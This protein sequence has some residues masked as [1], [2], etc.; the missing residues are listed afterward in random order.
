MAA[1]GA[2]LAGGDATESTST[3]G[4]MVE[5]MIGSATIGTTADPFQG[6]VTIQASNASYQNAAA[7][8]VAIGGILAIGL[9]M[10]NSSSGVT[11]LAQL[12]TGAT[13]V[14]TGTLDV[15]GTGTDQNV[16]TSIAGS[17]GLFSGNASVG[18]TSDTST[19]TAVLGGTIGASTVGFDATNN[20]EYD[21][22]V[23][24]VNATFAGYSGAFASNSD[25]SS[26]TAMVD[27]DTS[28]VATN[29]VVISALNTFGPTAISAN[30][31]GNVQAGS[32]GVFVGA[33]AE[34]NT[35]LA[36]T[37]SV[38]IGDGV[39]I[40]EMTPGNANSQG[41]SLSASSTLATD[42][43]VTLSAGGFCASANT[44]SSLVAT[45]T[46]N[47]TMS[48][49]DSFFTNQDLAIGTET[50]GGDQNTSAINTSGRFGAGAYATTVT[51]VTSNQDVTLGAGTH[52]FASGDVSLTPGLEYGYD[53]SSGLSIPNPTILSGN[54]DAQ[55]LRQ[56]R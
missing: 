56:A 5:A 55:C 53:Q 46:N 6:D 28:I 52:L 16:A 41:I 49:T 45:L 4:G 7:T 21:A 9:D 15:S 10:A 20:S 2:L 44:E 43:Q 47:V 11:T 32:G 34:D 35:V 24:S 12:G 14:I 54:S 26:A 27:S 48:G 25:T 38:N 13:I 51:D 1:A 22:S 36:G 31:T 33:A 17:A 40:M 37:S 50:T 18:T 3:S 39:S 23:D 29:A 19:V 30:A 8:G 42:D